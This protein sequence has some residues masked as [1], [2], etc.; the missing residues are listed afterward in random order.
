MMVEQLGHG[1]RT[2]QGKGHSQIQSLEKHVWKQL[3]FISFFCP[4]LPLPDSP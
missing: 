4:P 1:A 2:A 3:L